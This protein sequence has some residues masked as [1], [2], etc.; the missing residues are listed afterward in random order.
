ME[1]VPE[2]SQDPPASS[3]RL[4]PTP[5]ASVHG[6]VLFGLA[7]Q[8][9]ERRQHD[10]QRGGQGCARPC[11]EVAVPWGL[12]VGG[13]PLVGRGRDTAQQIHDTHQAT[14]VAE[15]G[16]RPRGATPGAAQEKWGA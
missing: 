6:T 1:E 13:P 3:Q 4:A 15:E 16:G 2:R 9:D 12:A 11:E 14:M 10:E 5:R 7:T 8:L